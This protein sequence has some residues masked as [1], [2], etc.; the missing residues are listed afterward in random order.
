MIR[1]LYMTPFSI[2]KVSFS[3]MIILF[4][5]LYPEGLLYIYF[6]TRHFDIWGSGIFMKKVFSVLEAKK[7]LVK[8]GLFH[9]YKLIFGNANLG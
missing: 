2:F 8:K 7:I 4:N 1:S 6:E 5:K 9:V 3:F